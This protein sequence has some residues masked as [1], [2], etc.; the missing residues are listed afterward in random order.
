MTQVSRTQLFQDTGFQVI[1]HPQPLPGSEFVYIGGGWPTWGLLILGLF[2]F[3][4]LAFPLGHM[5]MG[6]M[7][8]QQMI[9][10]ILLAEVGILHT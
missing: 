1:S 4:R 8:I 2:F 5:H 10:R 6:H 9:C 7:K 3:L